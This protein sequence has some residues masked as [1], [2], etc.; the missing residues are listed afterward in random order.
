VGVRRGPVIP[1]SAAE[2]GE[3]PQIAVSSA[4]WG[5]GKELACWRAGGTPLAG[6]KRPGPEGSNL[7]PDLDVHGSPGGAILGGDPLLRKLLLREAA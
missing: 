3:D 7:S 1:Q 5:R 2:A 6:E 4:P